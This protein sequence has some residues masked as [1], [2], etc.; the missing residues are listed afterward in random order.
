MT[1][2]IVVDDDVMRLA[3]ALTSTEHHSTGILKHGSEVRNDDRLREQIL[4]CAV[5]RGALPLPSDRVILIVKPMA[6]C[7]GK[8]ATLQTLAD[9]IGARSIAHPRFATVCGLPPQARLILVFTVDIGNE[10][11]NAFLTHKH[12]DVIVV[13]RPGKHTT[14]FIVYSLCRL[15]TEGLIGKVSIGMYGKRAL[16]RIELEAHQL[17]S[18][19]IHLRRLVGAEILLQSLPNDLLL[20]LSRE[21]E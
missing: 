2:G 18:A 19:N 9:G 12:R 1:S 20:R 21:V 3:I 14:Q 10:F 15:R 16:V 13:D 17:A 4:S 5:E 6:G 11:V 7:E 8:V